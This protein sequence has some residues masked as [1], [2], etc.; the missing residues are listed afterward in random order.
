MNLWDR[1]ACKAN[2]A[3]HVKNNAAKMEAAGRIDNADF[4]YFSNIYYHYV[5]TESKNG[6]DKR[7]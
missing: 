7:R 1:I 4:Q 6:I 3:A 2:R 5:A